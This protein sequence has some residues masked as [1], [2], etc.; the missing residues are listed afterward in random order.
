MGR[1]RMRP[2]DP[3]CTGLG[4]S[5][6]HPS[7]FRLSNHC[8]Q[9]HQQSLPLHQAPK[10]L[11]TMGWRQWTKQRTKLWKKGWSVGWNR[12]L[13]LQT[14]LPGPSRHK[15]VIQLAQSLLHHQ[16]SGASA[17][18]AVMAQEPE[19]R[20]LPLPPEMQ[21]DASVLQIRAAP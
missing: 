7:L 4:L 19:H 2:P 16:Q 10:V 8:Q 3:R 11:M 20:L 21:S 12:Y 1:H 9:S 14:L 13:A 17:T 18:S 6:R 5:R 15:T